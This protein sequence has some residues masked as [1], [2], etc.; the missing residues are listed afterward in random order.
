M[1]EE[2]YKALKLIIG[3]VKR[4]D[5]SKDMILADDKENPENYNLGDSIDMVDTWIEEVSKEY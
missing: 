4:S 2:T 1:N 5:M 3:L